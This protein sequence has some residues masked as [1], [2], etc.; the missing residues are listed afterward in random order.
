MNSFGEHIKLTTF[1]ESH[2]VAL[3]GV[4]E[5]F[6]AGVEIDLNFIQS[7]LDRRKPSHHKASTTRKESD[8]VEVLSGI[9]EGKTLGTPIAFIIRNENQQPDDYEYLREIFRPGHADFTYE[10]KYGHYDHR[11]GGRASARETASRVAAG[12]FAK[13]ILQ[14]KGVEIT[15]SIKQIG[16]AKTPEEIEHLIEQTKAEGDSLGGIIE[17]VIKGCPAGVGEPVFGKLQAQLAEAMMSIPAAKGFEYGEGF[18]SATM[19]GSEHNDVYILDE[20]GTD[21]TSAPAGNVKPATNHNGG[22]LGGISTGQDII[23]RVAFK[24]IASISKPQ[25]TVDK[26]GNPIE[27]VN[28]GRHDVCCVPRVLPVVEA[29]TAL[30]IL[31]RSFFL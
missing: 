15:A 8:R 5:G 1:G 6:P 9:F 18:A 30:V 28:Q 10:K 17:C 22:I 24:P 20:Y 29:M 31:D 21:E 12:A 3:G 7:E 13:T 26:K 16:T 4:I 27:L 23:F 19:K 11:S 2:G 25:Q 14:K